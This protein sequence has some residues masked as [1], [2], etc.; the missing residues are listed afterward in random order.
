[1]R[2][3]GTNPKEGAMSRRSL[4]FLATF[5]AIMMLLGAAAPAF[6]YGNVN[7]YHLRLTRLDSLRCG[8]PIAIQAK[9]TDRRGRPVSGKTINFAIAYGKPG[10]QLSP[11]SAVTNSR[12]KA[13][14]RV[15]LACTSG[16]HRTKIVAT[17]P[18]GAKARI[19]LVLT[20]HHRWW[21]DW[22]PDWDR[23]ETSA[24]L[25]SFTWVGAPRTGPSA[26]D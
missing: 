24:L 14:T 5:L 19:T 1:M 20:R 11:S 12:G 16:T 7:P 3:R 22:R 4:P 2:L 8:R 26:T 17:G 10:D 23:R 9:L 18:N 25:A 15:T 21:H 6:G 13:Y